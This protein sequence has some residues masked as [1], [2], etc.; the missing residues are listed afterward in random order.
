MARG[1]NTPSTSTSMIARRSKRVVSSE[2]SRSPD[3]SQSCNKATPLLN[4][5]FE[6]S[7]LVLNVGN[8][9]KL[10]LP[11][12]LS[13]MDRNESDEDEPEKSNVPSGTPFPN[14][15]P[16][17]TSRSGIKLRLKIGLAPTELPGSTITDSTDRA[18]ASRIGDVVAQRTDEQINIAS[19][20][21]KRIRLSRQSSEAYDS[22]SWDHDQAV[23]PKPSGKWAIY[24][25]TPPF[26]N[27][28]K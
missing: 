19:R 11:C 18:K 15:S 1:I 3:S 4:D 16:S 10:M 12:L 27:R 9:D 24:Y 28:L 2:P 23:I 20:S 22:T 25:C 13:D 17:S 5:G 14:V 26:R 21:S 6:G 7:R 8:F